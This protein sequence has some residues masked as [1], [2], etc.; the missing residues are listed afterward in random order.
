[1]NDCIAAYVSQGFGVN[2]F[3]F[4]SVDRQWDVDTT[5]AGDR[6]PRERLIV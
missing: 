5:V 3:L 6:L 4:V 1:M 2:Y